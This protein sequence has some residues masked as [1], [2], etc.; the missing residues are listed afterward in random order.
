MIRTCGLKTR[1]AEFQF[2]G[3]IPNCVIL[4]NDLVALKAE[5]FNVDEFK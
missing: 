5:E 1:A 3:L 4:K 2:S